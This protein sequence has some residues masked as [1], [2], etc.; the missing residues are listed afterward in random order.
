ME[1]ALNAGTGGWV[2]LEK[3]GRYSG[4]NGESQEHNNAP[5]M[6][7]F[8]AGGS[9]FSKQPSKGHNVQEKSG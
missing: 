6:L 3:K 4:I 1:S 8:N 9:C 7:M 5:T 2:A